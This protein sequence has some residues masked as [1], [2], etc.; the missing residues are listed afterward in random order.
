M[1]PLK[2]I[3]LL[4]LSL[5]LLFTSSASYFSVSA[6][7]SV[8]SSETSGGTSITAETV[9]VTTPKFSISVPTGIPIGDIAKTEK[10]SIKSAPFTVS[11]SNFAEMEGKQVQ[12]VLSTPYE[13]F[14]LWCGDHIL[15]YE[16][17]AQ[18]RGGTPIAM[19]G[20]FY[21]FTA[22]GTVT[23]RVEVDQLDIPAE[24]TYGG[25]LNFTFCV[26]DRTAQ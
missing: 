18:E 6:E 3:A 5:L 14:C 1:K 9:L 17:F 25:I 2:K 11:V 21:T 26:E 7:E 4:F 8:I 22:S 19:N 13:A 15:P 20:I 16:V 24:G 12:V 23:G 10:S